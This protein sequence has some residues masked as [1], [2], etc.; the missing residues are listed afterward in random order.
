VREIRPDDE[1]RDAQRDRR[2]KCHGATS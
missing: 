1:E 2:Q